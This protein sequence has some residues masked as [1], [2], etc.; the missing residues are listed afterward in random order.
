LEDCWF[1]LQFGLI[2]YF[3]QS[4]DKRIWWEF[5]DSPRRNNKEYLA[6]GARHGPFALVLVNVS[7]Q[8]VGTE[9]VNGARQDAWIREDIA[10]DRTFDQLS[11][12]HFTFLVV[13]DWFRDVT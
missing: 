13:C 11:V 1:S 4:S 9:R 6:D 8:T 2:S 7:P 12:K 5:V 3:K 10:A